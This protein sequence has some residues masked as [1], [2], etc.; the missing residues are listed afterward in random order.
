M[1][2]NAKTIRTKIL[3]VTVTLLAT[4][5][6]LVGGISSYINYSSTMSSLEQT[7]TETVEIAATQITTSLNIY[8]ALADEVSYNDSIRSNNKAE[9]NRVM[10]DMAKRHG[11]M[12]MGRTDSQGRTFLD[13]TDLS[14]TVYFT[15]AKS[16]KAA[17]VGTPEVSSDGNS[18]FMMISAPINNDGKFDGIVYIKMDASFLSDLVVNINV[19]ESGNASI[20]D[21]NGNT[22][23]Y[24]DRPT[25]LMA[26][27]TQKEAGSDPSLKRLAALEKLMLQ[28]N[29]GF[30]PYS[31]GG[32]EKFMAYAPIPQTG[33]GVYVSV[34]QAEFL[35]STYVGIGITIAVA[36]SLLVIGIIIIFGLSKTITTPV[37]LCS[38]RI[39]KL[40]EGDLTSPVPDIH[41]KDETGVLATSTATLV[42]G[43]QNIIHDETYLLDKMAGGDFDVETQAAENYIGDF[44]PILTSLKEISV[45]LSDALSQINV[46]SDQVSSGSD[47]VA[48]GAQALSQGST[49]QASAVEEL[50]ATIAEISSQ[51][52]NT[53][54]NA[55][56]ANSQMAD[57]GARLE[58]SNEQMMA[59]NKAMEDIS[60]KSSEIGKIIKTIEDIAF[61]TNIL[62]LNAAVEAARAGAAGKGFAVVAD[63]VRNLASKSAEAA[64]NTTD[65][66]EGS[67]QAV[68]RGK[69]IANE[70]AE[71]LF[72]VV[73]STHLVSANVEKIS[74]AARDQAASIS[75]VTQGIDQISSVVHTNSATAEESAA[76]SEELSGQAKILKDLVSRFI[77]KRL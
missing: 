7:M 63:E 59:M 2:K 34:E 23:A 64:K 62:A 21:E 9:V 53:A 65:L 41:T 20:I 55:V 40:A 49:E 56:T 8:S 12:E 36:V 70:T 48:S 57:A 52:N 42:N 5:L 33:W 69:E 27:N 75:Q 11:Y 24:A 13:G 15:R 25:V 73:D 4:A 18:I 10:E 72:S 17:F 44:S 58:K 3:A 76:T 77:L 14:G 71:S 29:S 1:F 45:K 47:Q 61:Q 66:I 37:K 30:D 35:G 39:R 74:N 67:I 50:A 60:S 26:Y 6:I 28:G 54:E 19:G 68:E 31:Y 38:E 46:A 22:I 51:I 16:D 32:V 43:L